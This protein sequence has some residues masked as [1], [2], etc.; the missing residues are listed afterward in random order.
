MVH[1]ASDQPSNHPRDGTMSES[2]AEQEMEQLRARI[3]ALEHLKDASEKAA[4]AQAGRLELSLEELRERALQ[5]E[6]SED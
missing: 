1:R 2:G 5:L 4:A 6:Q 3:A